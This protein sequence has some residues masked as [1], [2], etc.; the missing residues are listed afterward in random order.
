MM[1]LKLSIV[2]LST[3]LCTAC[4]TEVPAPLEQ[5]D[6]SASTCPS[7]AVSTDVDDDLVLPPAA[8]R[9][10]TDCEAMLLIDR[11]ARYLDA[12]D[13]T[14]EGADDAQR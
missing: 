5:A 7:P 1:R 9:T 11:R 8:S 4:T 10:M 13:Q 14:L 3:L 2:F 12:L 6:D